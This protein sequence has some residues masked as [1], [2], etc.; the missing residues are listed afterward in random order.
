MATLIEQLVD[1]K[2]NGFDDVADKV[3]ASLAEAMEVG[4]T[5]DVAVVAVKVSR[6]KIMVEQTSSMTGISKRERIRITHRCNVMSAASLV[7]L[8]RG[9]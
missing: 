1:L 3:H 7:T 4:R 9:A 5:K 8:L 2:S 6:I